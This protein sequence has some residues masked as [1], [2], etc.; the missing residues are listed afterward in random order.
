PLH[1]FDRMDAERAAAVYYKTIMYMYRFNASKGFLFHPCNNVDIEYIKT[2]QLDERRPR[3]LHLNIDTH[4]IS[5]DYKIVD[6][7]GFLYELGMIIPEAKDYGEFCEAMKKIEY[8][9]NEKIIKQ[10][11]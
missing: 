5:A 10:A 3:L 4:T 11:Q 6:T 2:K 8:S 9:Y 1:R 7:E